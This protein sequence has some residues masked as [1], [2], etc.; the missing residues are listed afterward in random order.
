MEGK[1]CDRITKVTFVTSHEVRQALRI[2]AARERK[3]MSTFIHDTLRMTLKE[4]ISY[5]QSPEIR[6]FFESLRVQ[7]I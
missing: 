6:E 1:V 5:L 4:E 2:L 3:T 7:D